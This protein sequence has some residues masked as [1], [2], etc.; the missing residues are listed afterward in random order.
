MNINDIWS[1]QDNDVWNEA[2]L[3]AKEETGRDNFIETKMLKLNVEYLKNLEVNDFYN[4][5]HDDYFLWKYT[6][7]N[8]LAT[9]RKKLEEYVVD[10]K[11]L[12]D[13]QEELFNF[14]LEKTRM[15][16][17]VAV[18]IKGLG[19]AGAS[20]LLSL[21]YPSYF[22]TVDDMVIRALLST[23]GYK[24]DETI[25]SMN[26]KNIKIDEAVYLINIFKKKANELN[27]LFN[28]Y[29]WT[30]RDIDV[31]LWFFRDNK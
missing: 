19:I 27:K 1:S 10:M 24:D 28:Q 31:I 20:G 3:S 7:K 16:L 13:I 18:Q 26:P 4:F 29:C 8:R 5:L 25:K 15:G 6:A 9:T 22:G 11:E 2:L 21:L 17:N 12:K 30:P 23:N 14:K